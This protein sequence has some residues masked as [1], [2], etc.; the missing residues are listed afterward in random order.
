MKRIETRLYTN[1][2][3]KIKDNKRLTKVTVYQ[4]VMTVEPLVKT[5]I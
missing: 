1:D 3:K 4:D 5:V 2:E